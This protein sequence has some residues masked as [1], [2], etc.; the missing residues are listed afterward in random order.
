MMTT[1][2]IYFKNYITTYL[3]FFTI[4]LCKP[5]YGSTTSVWSWSGIPVCYF[6]SLL[7]WNIMNETKEKYSPLSCVNANSAVDGSMKSTVAQAPPDLNIMVPQGK[8]LLL[9]ICLSEGSSRPRIFR[10][11]SNLLIIDGGMKIKCTVYNLDK[12]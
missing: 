3:A 7:V 2:Q 5:L 9:I 1:P 12:G 6:I 4:W 10:I 11:N 8:F